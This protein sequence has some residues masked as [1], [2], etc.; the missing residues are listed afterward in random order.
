VPRV[1]SKCRGDRSVKGVR[2]NNRGGEQKR[3]AHIGRQHDQPKRQDIPQG[4][5]IAIVQKRQ[6]RRQSV[7][8]KELLT[9]Q[10]NNHKTRRVTE[11]DDSLGDGAFANNGVQLALQHH[12]EA[13]G[14]P[15][16]RPE[17]PSAHH[18]RSNSLSPSAWMV[19]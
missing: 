16:A 12:G 2:V 1:S 17:S 15:A 9:P 7:L 3:S 14:R 13:D 5:Q 11:G 8:G 18:V 6:D 4:R 10:H 19:S